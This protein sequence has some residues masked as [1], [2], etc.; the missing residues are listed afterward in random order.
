MHNDHIHML[1]TEHRPR[2]LAEYTPSHLEKLSQKS[3]MR[4]VCNRSYMV[5][6]CWT[7][8]FFMP[9]FGTRTHVGKSLSCPIT[10]ISD[11]GTMPL[12]MKET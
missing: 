9:C 10:E 1:F 6:S 7:V 4:P 8:S 11:R 5:I 12:W 3:P 2:T